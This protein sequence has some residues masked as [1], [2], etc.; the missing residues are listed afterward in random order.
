MMSL[1]SQPQ[2]DFGGPIFNRRRQ[3][4]NGHGHKRGAPEPSAR[5]RTGSSGVTKLKA[6]HR[7]DTDQ[8]SL[9]TRR[10]FVGIGTI[11]Q[12]DERG[13]VDKPGRHSHAFAMTSSLLR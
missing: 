13:L 5:L 1:I 4:L 7:T 6:G 9:D 10:P 2:L 8:T 12:A 11:T 3:V